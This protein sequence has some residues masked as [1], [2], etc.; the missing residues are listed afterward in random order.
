MVALSLREKVNATIATR[1]S[2]FILTGSPKVKTAEWFLAAAEIWCGALPSNR[3]TSFR[4]RVSL[5]NLVVS[6]I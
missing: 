5:A 1:T 2:V 3:S 6:E 4:S